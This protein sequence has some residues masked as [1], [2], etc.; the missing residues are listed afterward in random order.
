MLVDVFNQKKALVGAFSVLLKTDGSF[1]ALIEVFVLV[2]CPETSLVDSRDFLQP[3]VTP[4]E[5][6][7]ACSRGAEWAGKL[8][9][10]FQE[11]LITSSAGVDDGGGGVDV[12]QEKEDGEGD[13]S[14]ITGKV[15]SSARSQEHMSGGQLTV[16]ND[17]TIR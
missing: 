17:K 14:L 11:L 12:D 16:I 13:V 15:R 7:L 8:V 10:D 5:F 3:I 1:A 6:E 4:Y 9:T 2:A